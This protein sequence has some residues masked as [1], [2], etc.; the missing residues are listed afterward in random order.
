MEMSYTSFHTENMKIVEKLLHLEFHDKTM[1]TIKVIIYCNLVRK[2]RMCVWMHKGIKKVI[3]VPKH[4]TRCRNTLIPCSKS[5]DMFCKVIII[6]FQHICFPMS[7]FLSFLLQ[8]STYLFHSI[9][10]DNIAV[11]ELSQH[12]KLS[13]LDVMR[14]VVAHH[15]KHF[16]SY[17]LTQLL[18]KH[19]QAQM[20]L[21]Q[22]NTSQRHGRTSQTV[23]INILTT[24]CSYPT[25]CWRLQV[26]K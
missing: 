22:P 4:E 25:S 14:A 19:T 20:H 23:H 21:N 8:W 2:V 26:S 6:S 24:N 15:V 17:Q 12:L 3:P 5:V 16:D 1:K 18:Q 9:Q 13:H 11:V 10:P 7:L